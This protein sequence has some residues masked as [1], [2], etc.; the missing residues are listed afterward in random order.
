METFSNRQFRLLSIKSE[1][2]LGFDGDRD[3][4]VEHVDAAG[5]E[6]RGTLHSDPSGV[7]QCAFREWQDA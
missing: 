3:G 1:E 6:K 2:Y 5:S 7:R 4:Y